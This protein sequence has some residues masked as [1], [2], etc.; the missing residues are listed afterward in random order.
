[1][2]KKTNTFYTLYPADL[3]VFSNPFFNG[4][5]GAQ[6]IGHWLCSG[7][8]L[9]YPSIARWFL[10][11]VIFDSETSRVT[12]RSLVEMNFMGAMGREE[13]ARF[14]VQKLVLW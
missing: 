11:V 14:A 12:G 13:A 10:Q 6:P 7:G 5:H 4:R 3:D 1:M 9:Y 8:A 2:R